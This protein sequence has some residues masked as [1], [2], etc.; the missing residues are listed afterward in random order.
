[1]CRFS[2]K[3]EA[4]FACAAVR[5]DGT[6]LAAP[7]EL[8]ALIGGWTRMEKIVIGEK[9]VLGLKRD[10]TVRSVGISGAV[11]PDVSGWTDIMDLGTG[12]DYCAG[13][14]SSG[15]MALPGSLFS[16]KMIREG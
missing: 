9:W 16:G 13:V 3:G 15:A 11:P 1:M 8:A 14:K 2:E 12:Q 10:G 7:A 5:K 6:V 4:R